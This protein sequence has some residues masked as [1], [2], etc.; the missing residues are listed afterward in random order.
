L[1][2]ASNAGI[3]AV[4]GAAINRSVEGATNTNVHPPPLVVMSQTTVSGGLSPSPSGSIVYMPLGSVAV[5]A[6]I[7]LQLRGMTTA[8]TDVSTAASRATV[9]IP[10]ITSHPARATTTSPP[11][12]ARIGADGPTA[13]RMA[14]ACA[15]PGGW[16]PWGM[17]FPSA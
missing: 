2:E 15:D 4:Y 5:A 9:L 11:A 7:S 10:K 6:W 16:G 17:L 12:T 8:S 1:A 13:A 14:Q 3:V